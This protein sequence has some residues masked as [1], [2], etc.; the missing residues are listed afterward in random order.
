MT[1]R[2]NCAGEISLNAD[3]ESKVIAPNKSIVAG[4]FVQYYT[5]SYSLNETYDKFIK[6]S[7]TLYIGNHYE[8]NNNHID[9]IKKNGDVFSIIDAYYTNITIVDIC[10]DSSE[11]DIFYALED[12]SSYSDPNYSSRILVFKVENNE[13]SLLDATTIQSS[14]AANKIFHYGSHGSHSSVLITSYTYNSTNTSTNPVYITTY[15]KTTE[16][17][18][19]YTY[20]KWGEWSGNESNL[21]YNFP[22]RCANGFVKDSNNYLYMVGATQALRSSSRD[23]TY[24]AAAKLHLGSDGTPVIDLYKKIYN[25]GLVVAYSLI[26]TRPEIIDG[27]VICAV[28]EAN[29]FGKCY[30]VDSDT[31]NAGS[32]SISQSYLPSNLFDTNKMTSYRN[33]YEINPATNSGTGIYSGDSSLSIAK[34]LVTD[35]G[36]VLSANGTIYQIT[37]EMTEVHGI[38]DTDYVIPFKKPGNPIGVAKE[39]G[40]AGDT[41]DV[42]I[43]TDSY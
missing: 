4:D 33:I 7:N 8:T 37:N 22:S 27:K 39:S 43:A 30:I 20:T 2:T 3:I 16:N 12:S 29:R 34:A 23:Y 1:G 21:S 42:Y 18:N 11:T 35:D 26:F 38:E 14:R 36:Y 32:F 24:F 13:I 19:D 10:A 9:L 15:Y 41:I 40:S 25:D 28:V 6:L 17:A 31:L 5:Q